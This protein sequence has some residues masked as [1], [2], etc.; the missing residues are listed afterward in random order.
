MG[1]LKSELDRRIIGCPHALALDLLDY[2]GN[3]EPLPRFRPFPPP[4]F[5]R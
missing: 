4:K 1:V 3:I 2:L 5:G